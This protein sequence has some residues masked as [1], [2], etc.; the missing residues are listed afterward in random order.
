MVSRRT[1]VAVGLMLAG[2]TG[3]ARSQEAVPGVRTEVVRLDAVVTDANG[4]LVR[5]LSRE[6]PYKMGGLGCRQ[7]AA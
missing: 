6:E 4:N 1:V 5:D 7:H 2:A 3:A